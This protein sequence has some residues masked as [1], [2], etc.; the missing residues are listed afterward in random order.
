MTETQSTG[1][2]YC[3]SAEQVRIA[4]NVTDGCATYPTP[5]VNAAHDIILAFLQSRIPAYVVGGALAPYSPF[6][7]YS[8][9]T[10]TFP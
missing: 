3:P 2:P 7:G 9:T 4:I 10:G 5:I 8:T 6:V 1:T